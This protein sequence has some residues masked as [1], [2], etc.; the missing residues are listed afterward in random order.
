[1][2]LNAPEFWFKKNWQSL[3]LLP[4]SLIWWLI[5][6]IRQKFITPYQAQAKIIIVGGAIVGGSG[7][8]PFTRYIRAKYPKSVVLVKSYQQKS[9]TFLISPQ[10]PC[11]FDE[12][13]L[14]AGDGATIICDTRVNGIKLAQSLGFSTIIC[15]DGLQDPTICGDYIYLVIDGNLGF[16][17]GFLL[18]AGPN[19]Q[20][21]QSAMAKCHEIIQIQG[22]QGRYELA[23]KKYLYLHCALQQNADKNAQYYAFAGIAYPKKF[24]ELALNQGFNIIKFQNFP[25]HHQY[26]DAEIHEICQFAQAHQLQI[27]TTE[28]DFAKIPPQFH[29]QI[30]AL[31][32]IFHAS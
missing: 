11:P 21:P 19:R 15:D 2:N 32:L 12:A 31:N 10:N 5:F 29:T 30:Q 28:K 27:I 18:P 25:D 23:D 13:L 8:T 14:H 7:K 17:N 20:S 9:A 24:Y 1:M 6:L 4:F 3:I 22:A 16:G 26:K